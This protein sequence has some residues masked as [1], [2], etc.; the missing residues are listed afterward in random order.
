IFS[1]HRMNGGHDMGG[2]RDMCPLEYEKN[3]PVFHAPWEGRIS[4]AKVTPLGDTSWRLDDTL[5]ETEA[6]C[7]FVDKQGPQLERLL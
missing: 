2:Q 5:S 3:E 4:E 6:D 1:R 7:V